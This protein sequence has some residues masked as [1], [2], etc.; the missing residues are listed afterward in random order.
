M[1]K[2]HRRPLSAP[3]HHRKQYNASA[4]KA[5]RRNEEQM[6]EE[7]KKQFEKQLK[8]LKIKIAKDATEI[9]KG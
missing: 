1:Q 9:C 3:P 7:Q 6:S 2:T 4:S 8:A 5:L